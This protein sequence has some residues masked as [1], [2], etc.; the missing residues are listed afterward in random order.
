VEK[1][2]SPGVKDHAD[3]IRDKGC[4]TLLVSYSITTLDAD[5]TKDSALVFLGH[6]APGENPGDKASFSKRDIDSRN[7]LALKGVW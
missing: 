3:G 7:G 5:N 4:I 1:V 2:A 6:L